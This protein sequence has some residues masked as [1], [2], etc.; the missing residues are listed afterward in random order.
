MELKQ[1]FKNQFDELRA[2]W[3]L[4]LFILA[5]AVA[6]GIVTIPFA[7]VLKMTDMLLLSALTLIGVLIATYI[8][9]RF[10]NRKPFN[11]IGLAINKETMQQLGIGCLAGFLMMT[12]IFGVEYALGYVKVVATE[13]SFAQALQAFGLALLFF[14]VAGMFE[15]VL[16]RGYAFQTLVRGIKFIPASILVGA[17][18]GLAHLRNPNASAFGIINTTLVS[19]LFCLA[20]WRTRS[21]WLPFGIHFA[22]NFSQTTLYGFRTSGV[23]FSRYELTRLTQFGTDWITGGAY[24]PEGGALATL[25]IILCGVYIYFSRFLKPHDGVVVLERS[26]EKLDAQIFELRTQQPAR[27]LAA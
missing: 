4:L 5:F 6:S 26:D 15:E 1:I 20:Y 24:G 10:I 13:F 27:R 19:V 11:A 3:Q 18:F 25:A 9:T 7:V 16:F 17:L 23:D 22:W 8:A 14:G 21:L 2:G 12:G